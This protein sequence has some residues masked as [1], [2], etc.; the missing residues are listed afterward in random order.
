MTDAKKFDPKK[1]K[2][3]N[4]PIRLEWIPPALIWSLINPG[5]GSTFVDI[6]AG[7]G[8]LTNKIGLLAGPAI[9]IHALDI[10]PL[11]IAEMRQ[12]LPAESTIIPQLMEKDRLPFADNSIDGIWLITLFHELEP[13]EPLLAE[14][15]RVLRPGCRMLIV[16]WEKDTAACEQGPPFAHRIAADTALQTVTAA[17]FA[18]VRQVPGFHFHYGIL[19]HA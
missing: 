16:D 17:G 19:A 4:N 7:T 14:I 2:K 13:P 15:H 9:E 18:D 10:E 11:M 5:T 6:G 12:T 8:Y 3:L 1:R